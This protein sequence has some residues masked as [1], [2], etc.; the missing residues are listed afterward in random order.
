MRFFW[1]CTA[2]LALTTGGNLLVAAEV[3]TEKKNEAKP[4]SE[5]IIGT[6]VLES[7][8]RT[9]DVLQGDGQSVEVTFGETSFQFV[10]LKDGGKVL[11]ISGTY[12]I[13]D[14]QTPKIFDVTL[15]GDGGANM[16]YAIY[17]LDGDKFRTRFRDNNGPRPADFESPAS[18]CQTLSYKRKVDSP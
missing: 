10:V 4:D 16:I 14:K 8:D 17:E 9:S 7:S 11:E 15:T 2:V 18:D 12:V 1:L 3:N 5:A 13:D 6:W